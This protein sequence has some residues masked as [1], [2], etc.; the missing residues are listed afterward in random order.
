MAIEIQ[1]QLFI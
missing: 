1:E